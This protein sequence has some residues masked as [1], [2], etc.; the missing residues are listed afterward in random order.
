MQYRFTQTIL[1]SLYFSGSPITTYINDSS[2]GF[3]VAIHTAWW[4]TGSTDGVLGNTGSIDNKDQRYPIILQGIEFECG[5][6]EIPVDCIVKYRQDTTDTTK[7]YYAP[8]IVNTVTNQS[9]DITSNYVDIG[10]HIQC[11]DKDDESYIKYEKYKNGVYLP[12]LVGGSS[13][14]Y[15]RDTVRRYGAG[16]YTGNVELFCFGNCL[17][18]ATNFGLS[19]LTLGSV[20]SNTWW[21]HCSRLSPN[22]NRGYWGA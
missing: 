19:H 16:K 9:T 22:G 2:T 17:W 4:N 14:T 21:D 6:Y 15:T 18:G 8:Y 3:T 11:P 12:C 1:H 20:L 7:Y 5:Q 13:S 10:I